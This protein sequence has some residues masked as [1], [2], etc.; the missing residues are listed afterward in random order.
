MTN[1]GVA[2]NPNGAFMMQ[3]VR[4]LTDKFDGFLRIHPY[5]IMD[6]DTRFTESFRNTLDRKGV[7]PG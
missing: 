7:E 5:L 6:R 2:P 3:I 4:N 1:A